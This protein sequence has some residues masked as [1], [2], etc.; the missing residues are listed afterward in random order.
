MQLLQAQLA[1]RQERAQSLHSTVLEL[2]HVQRRLQQ[3]RTA[4]VEAAEHASY[5]DQ[6]VG[7]GPLLAFVSPHES[8]C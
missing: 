3:R 7:G 6:Q 8:T 1:V 2:Q 4:L 5:A